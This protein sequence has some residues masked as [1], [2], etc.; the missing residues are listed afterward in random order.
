[1][2]GLAATGSSGTASVIIP[3]AATFIGTL[4]GYY[5]NEELAQVYFSASDSINTLLNQSQKRLNLQPKFARQAEQ[6]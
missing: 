3:L 5:Q 6:G 4:F 2:G 1:L